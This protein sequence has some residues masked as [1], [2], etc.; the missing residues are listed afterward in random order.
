MLFSMIGLIRFMHQK[1]H[2][3]ELKLDGL[4]CLHSLDVYWAGEIL[5]GVESVGRARPGQAN[6]NG[7]S[8][9]ISK[10]PGGFGQIGRL[11][12]RPGQSEPMDPG[13]GRVNV[14]EE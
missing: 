2:A 5:G 9:A 6:K 14:A 13:R 7:P 10:P 4:N 8:T 11:R 3:H 1:F 12:E